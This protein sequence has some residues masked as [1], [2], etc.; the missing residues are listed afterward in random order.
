MANYEINLTATQIESALNKAHAP[1]T[2][3]DNTQNLVES[4][5]IKTYV[6]TQVSAGASITTAS[7]AGS[8][9][10]DSVEGITATDTAIPTSKAVKEAVENRKYSTGWTE[11]SIPSNGQVTGTALT[12]MFF[13]AR[14]TPTSTKQGLINYYVNNTLEFRVEALRRSS[15]GT[16][17]ATDA[18]MFMPV[19]KGEVYKFIFND[20]I[21]SSN[22]VSLKY[23]TFG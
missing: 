14:Q 9:L 12:D 6:D 1:A 17:S 5:A 3:V 13:I 16:D 20:D 10:E 11:V 18:T 8:A 23:K 21:L 19:A 15:S 2:V 22:L 7:F 4:G